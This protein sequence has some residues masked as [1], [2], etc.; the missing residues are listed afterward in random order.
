MICSFPR[1]GSS[2]AKQAHL[3]RR[4]S[5]QSAYSKGGLLVSFFRSFNSCN[6]QDKAIYGN[7]KCH[8]TPGGKLLTSIHHWK[9]ISE[10]A[11]NSDKKVFFA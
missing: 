6:W 2:S 5:E 11:G 10:K 7:E 4:L 1:L 8:K 9:S 3:E